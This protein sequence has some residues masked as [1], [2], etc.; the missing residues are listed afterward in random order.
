MRRVLFLSLGLS[1]LSGCEVLPPVEER[2]VPM[3]SMDASVLASLD[4]APAQDAN[5]APPPDVGVDADAAPEDAALFPAGDAPTLSSGAFGPGCSFTVW[6]SPEHA[7][8]FHSCALPPGGGCNCNGVVRSAPPTD[9]AGCLQTLSSVCG[10]DTTARSGCEHA[11]GGGC[12]PS[13]SASDAWQ[14]ECRTSGQ[15]GE[16]RAASC[17]AAGEALCKPPLMP[18]EDKTGRCKPN[19]EGTFTCE[20]PIDFPM[21]HTVKSD[22]CVRALRVACVASLG[23]ARSGDDCM[24]ASF[25]AGT[26]PMGACFGKDRQPEDGFA[27]QCDL[28]DGNSRQAKVV[29]PSCSAALGYFCPEAATK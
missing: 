1:S 22:Q 7:P 13:V 3:A 29:A 9:V 19:A 16:L 11:Y 8:A 10:V 20:C 15:R 14:C 18:C 28:G 23:L 5:L 24:S 26:P 21:L 27:C 12:W 4:A 6:P 2:P 25:D 17:R